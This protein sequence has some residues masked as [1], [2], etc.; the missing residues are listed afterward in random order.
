[1][2]RD[3]W[4][5]RMWSA[6]ETS[7]ARPFVY[8]EW[9]C[10]HAVAQVLDAMTGSAWSSEIAALYRDKRSALR[11]LLRSGGLED[12]VTARLGLP[13]PRNLARV[14]DVVSVDLDTGPAIGICVGPRIAIAAMPSGFDYAPL[15]RARCAWRI[16]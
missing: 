10:V 14:G 2:R 1:M 16:D 9:D 13:V 8:G 5:P 15:E 4:Q 12:L 11:L 7:C 6:I 3:D